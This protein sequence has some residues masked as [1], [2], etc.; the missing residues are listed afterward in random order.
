MYTHLTLQVRSNGFHFQS[1]GFEGDEKNSDVRFFCLHIF[2]VVY[3]YVVEF[4]YVCFDKSTFFF[5]NLY[6]NGLNMNASMT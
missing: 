4:L 3:C 1:G 6:Q 5:L 2:Y